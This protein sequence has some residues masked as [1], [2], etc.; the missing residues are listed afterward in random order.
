MTVDSITKL[1]EKTLEAVCCNG[2]IIVKIPIRNENV[3][4]K[5]AKF[6]INVGKKYNK[7]DMHI[8]Q[9]KLFTHFGVKSST[10]EVE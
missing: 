4:I 8:L 6:F 9:E 2:E 10:L 7:N 5:R 1:D 3:D